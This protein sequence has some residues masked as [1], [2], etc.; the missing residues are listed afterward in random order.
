MQSLFAVLIIA[1]LWL[2]GAMIWCVSL[3]LTLL[4]AANCLLLIIVSS[5][6]G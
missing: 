2:L 1:F 5:E 3:P 4:R 6:T